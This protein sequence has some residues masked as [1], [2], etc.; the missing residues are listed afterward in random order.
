[1]GHRWFGLH[2]VRELMIVR[3]KS[4]KAQRPSVSGGGHLQ[5]EFGSNRD[6][7]GGYQRPEKHPKNRFS[8]QGEV[9]PFHVP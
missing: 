1:M 6:L 5:S 3:E 4:R 7:G 9:Y 8:H 2:P